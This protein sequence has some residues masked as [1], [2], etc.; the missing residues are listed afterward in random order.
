MDKIRALRYFKRVAE[1]HSFS[2][3]AQ[4]FHVPASSISRRIKDLEHELGLE[5]IKRTTRNVSLTELGEVYYNSIL[6]V[7]EKLDDADKLVSQ[8]HGAL[9]GKIRI[10]ALASFGEKVLAP[11]L[12]KFRRAYPDIILDLDFSDDRVVFSQD[13]VDIAIRARKVPDER[14]I[15]KP[16]AG[17]TFKLVA[18][19]ELLATLQARYGKTRLSVEDLGSCPTLQGRGPYGLV[20]WWSLQKDQWQ[21]I[22][23]NPI[24]LCNCGES[25]LAAILA[26]EGLSV[27]PDWWVAP[28]LDSGE[29]VEVPT[30]FQV[31]NLQ[32]TELEMFILYQQAKYQLPKIKHCVD[33]IVQHLG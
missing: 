16:L 31:S 7:L 8:H 3:A 23:I 19:P 14:V 28:Y 11:V 21:R 25:I 10:S 12:Q 22:D 13:S 18:T 33:F 9:E 26:H 20:S 2:L 1:L 30:Q 5:L 24:M 27:F 15:A 32:G 17:S 6:E 29:L 4:E